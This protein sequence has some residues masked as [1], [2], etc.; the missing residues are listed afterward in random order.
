[1]GLHPHC[2]PD[3]HLASACA[4]CGSL[5]KGAPHTRLQWLIWSGSMLT[6]KDKVIGI[7]MTLQPPSCIPSAHLRISESGEGVPWWWT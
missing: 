4:G 3:S 7:P 6:C 2:H 1:M 5:P